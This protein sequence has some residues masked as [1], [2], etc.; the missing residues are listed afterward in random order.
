[1]GCGCGRKSGNK[2]KNTKG[3]SLDKYGFLTPQQIALLK[4]KEE[5]EKEGKN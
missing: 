1:M 2:N 3:T 5:K 4:A